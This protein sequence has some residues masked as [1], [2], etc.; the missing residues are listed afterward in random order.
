MAMD[1]S[2][3]RFPFPLPPLILGERKAKVNA[4]KGPWV[5]LAPV[6]QQFKGPVESAA[7]TL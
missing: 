7:T 5:T 1:L 2:A 6:V 4:K 3:A